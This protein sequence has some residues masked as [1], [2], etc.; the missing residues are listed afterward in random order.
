[1]SNRRVLAI[2]TSCDETAAAVHDDTYGI[3]SNALYSQ[4]EL[5]AAYGGV[6]PEIASRSHIEKIM[7]IVDQSL[8]QA[9]T[10]LSQISCIGVTHKPGLPG[11]LLVGLSYAKALAFAHSI[12][13]V[14]IDHIEAHI[15]SPYLE[16]NVPV[17]H[18]GITASG[19]HTLLYYVRDIV[20]Y[21]VIG[22][23][24]DD[25]AGEAMDKVAKLLELG[26]PGGPQIEQLAREVNFQDFFHY[27]R[28]R[29]TRLDLSF[30]GLKTAVLYD[31]IER[32]AYDQEQRSLTAQATYE[33]KQKVA[34][35]LLV[36]I[37]DMFIAKL[38]IALRD[39]PHTQ[40]ITFA[41]GVA[42][43]TYIRNRLSTYA[44]E[45]GIPCYVPSPRYCTD[46][47]AMIA[48]LTCHFSNKNL[49][50]TLY[51]DIHT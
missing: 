3:V 21:N 4:T 9:D 1:M 13:L 41:G 6:V 39:Y 30:S 22:R 20:D 32:G 35:S 11:S 18:I 12:P 7:P 28:G 50:S 2:E 37:A 8:T 46:N 34:S 33:L 16:H 38:R 26:Y 27:P 45:H 14:G 51:L 24:K 40:A 25:A 42:C 49:Y 36:C 19:G 48:Y 15:F 10:N 47:A 17:P 23:T 43:N 29:N 5:H 44:Q 31:L